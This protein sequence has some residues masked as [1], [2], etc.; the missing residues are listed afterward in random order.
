VKFLLAAILV[1]VVQ[2]ASGCGGQPFP[3]ETAGKGSVAEPGVTITT[4]T[5]TTVPPTL[6]PISQSDAAAGNRAVF[7]ANYRQLET[8]LR[9]QRDP[10]LSAFSFDGPTNTLSAEFVFEHP[11]RESR[12]EYDAFAWHVGQVLSDTFWFPQLV[13]SLQSQHEDAAALLPKLRIRLDRISYQ[14]PAAVEIAVDARRISQHD[15]LAK[16]AA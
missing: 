13:Q 14:C 11:A 8:A 1:V 2:L 10:A 12:A 4:A 9:S 5:T 6:G 7:L 3:T 16:C 15:W